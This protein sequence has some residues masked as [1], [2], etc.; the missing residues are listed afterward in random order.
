MGS[1]LRVERSSTARNQRRFESRGRKSY[2]GRPAPR[3]DGGRRGGPVRPDP[4]TAPQPNG[5]RFHLCQGRV[6]VWRAGS[7]GSGEY[8]GL[9]HDGRNAAQHRAHAARTRGCRAAPGFSVARAASNVAPWGVDHSSGS[10]ASA[11]STSIVA[12]ANGV[13]TRPSFTSRV[14]ATPGWKMSLMRSCRCRTTC[15]F[16]SRYWV[17]YRTSRKATR[18]LAMRSVKLHS[19]TLRGPMLSR[20]FVSL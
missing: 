18:G 3:A 19:A 6:E 17:W 14:A 10:K 8:F 15:P 7:R 5:Q 13:V 1:E 2:R 12:E 4:G 16:A 9:L 11:A 20:V